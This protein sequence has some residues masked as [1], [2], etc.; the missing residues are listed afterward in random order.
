MAT[1]QL[2][3]SILLLIFCTANAQPPVGQW[4]DYF[5]L[6]D[7]KAVS[8]SGQSISCAASNGFFTFN[9]ET[10]TLEKFT[11]VNGLSGVDVSSILDIPELGITVVG[12]A[13]GNI[14]FIYNDTKQV[15]SIPFIME[16]PMS[17]S[18]RI[19]NFLYHDALIYTSTDF[20]IVV[21][22]PVKLEVKDTYYV[23]QNAGSLRVRKM[24]FWGNR[25]WVASNQGV[26][27][28]NANDPLLINYE[29]WRHENFFTN[30]NAECISLSATGSSL[31]AV[32]SNAGFDIVWINSNSSWFELDRP[33]T[34]VSG[35]AIGFG[36]IL[37]FSKNAIQSY[38]EQ[39]VKGIGLTSYSFGGTPSINDCLF[40]DTNRIALADNFNGLV[41]GTLVN[42]KISTPTGPFSNNFFALDVS[43]E[44]VVGAAGSYDNAFGNIWSPF[45]AHIYNGTRWSY[46]AD[47]FQHDAVRVKFDPQNPMRYYVAS[48]GSGLYRFSGSEMDGHFTP[49]NSTL[50]SVFPGQPYCRIA[51][52]DLDSRGNLWVANSEA[53][54]P[55]SVLTQ[56]GTWKSFAYAGAINTGRILSL[57][58]SPDQN[59]WLALALDYGLFVLNPGSSIENISDDLYQK[60]RP[61]DSNGNTF[62]NEITSLAF[63]RDGYLWLGTNQGVLVSYNPQ[64]VFQGE[65]F[66]QKIKIPDV[67]PGLAVYLLETEEI[68]CIDVDGGNRKWFGTSKSG[69]FLFSADGTKQIHHFNTSNSPLPSNTILSIKV[70]PVSGEV[71]IATEKG[72]ISF[73]GESNQPSANF[74]NVYAFPNPVRPSYSGVVTIT[75]LMDNSVVKITDV[76]GN[77][78]YETRSNGGMA[79]WDGKTKSGKRVAT[80]VY[81]V[82]CSDSSGKQAAVTKILFI[83]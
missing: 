34:D 76:A 41:W 8:L 80:G 19:N 22:D 29:Q 69:V 58:V 18:K 10:G 45:I 74:D 23:V 11:T 1:K 50:Q 15:I 16:K 73:R 5:A 55:I 65:T 12:F 6:N 62:L 75:G 64:R 30:P 3:T 71:F 52:M 72:L 81:L 82:F 54:N 63:D 46:F 4:R 48:W 28:A 70:H 53:A 57:T 43:S 14:N 44:Y 68:S 35:V 36:K 83:K 42:Q 24:V 37:V 25:F 47:W 60:F 67:V 66:F 9:I 17:G 21:I 40:I 59:I 49:E 78:V 51:G 31:V 77:L 32:E 33:Y 26:F 39:R 79:T 56:Q 2:L 61:R 27:S 38:S 13:S 20:G 7:A